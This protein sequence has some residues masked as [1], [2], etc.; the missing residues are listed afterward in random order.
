MRLPWL[1]RDRVE[2][3]SALALVVQD[4]APLA[5]GFA[6]LA[7]D[8][9]ILHRWVSRL[10][11]IDQDPEPVARLQVLR[12]IDRDEASWLRGRYGTRGFAVALTRIA[13][14]GRPVA[15]G[16]LFVRYYPLWLLIAVTA[17]PLAVW[18]AVDA[19]QDGALQS[20]Y[21]EMG[22]R[23]PPLTAFL[24]LVPWWQQVVAVIA[25]YLVVGAA[26]VAWWYQP[27][28]HCLLTLWCPAVFRA[29][30]AC[31]LIHYAECASWQVADRFERWQRFSERLM[32]MSDESERPPWWREWK[33][34][35]FLTDFIVPRSRR[36]VLDGEHDVDLLARLRVLGLVI[37]GEHGVDWETS[38]TLAHDRLKDAQRRRY[39]WLW[40]VLLMY[41]FLAFMYAAF[42]PLFT[43]VKRL[44]G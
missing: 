20:L 3:L 9:P 11:D 5:A 34:Y 38:Y 14:G 35:W 37:D 16:T 17:V 24:L 41:G 15:P 12:L 22:L 19:M 33:L 6:A 18:G 28:F 23:L 30:L 2:V 10:A 27:V 39:P 26:L 32:F 29:A 40:T 36:A 4:D 13:A 8:D 1:H 25:L 21:V 31:R 7:A 44:G 43:I 42:Q